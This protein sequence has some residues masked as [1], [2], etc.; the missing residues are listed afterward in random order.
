MQENLKLRLTFNPGLELTGFRTTRSW[1]E[2]SRGAGAKVIAV[3]KHM[4][5]ASFPSLNECL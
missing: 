3:G 5:N 2:D 1:W 4:K